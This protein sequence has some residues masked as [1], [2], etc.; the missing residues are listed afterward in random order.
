MG[1]PAETEYQAIFDA[2]SDGL[3]I[4]DPDTGIVLGANAAFCR[5][6]GHE[7][8]VGL[9]PTAFV[10]QWLRNGAAIPDANTASYTVGEGDAGQ[11]IA[12]RVTASNAGGSNSRTSSAVTPRAAAPTL[13]VTIPKQS[14]AGKP[15]APRGAVARRRAQE[16]PQPSPG[17][18]GADRTRRHAPE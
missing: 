2:T 3:V 8:M 13:S 14:R 11:A 7:Q 6:H 5:M 9:H 17:S 1:N 16:W 4:N 12:C 18:P 15:R 10:H